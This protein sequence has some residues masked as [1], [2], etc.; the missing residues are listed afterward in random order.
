MSRTASS[1][2]H[3][4]PTLE[5]LEFRRF[6]NAASVV[7][8]TFELTLGNTLGTALRKQVSTI[9]FDLVG[10]DYWTPY[11]VIIDWGDGQT[12]TYTDT[13][14]N[15]VRHTYSSTGTYTVTASATTASGT[16]SAAPVQWNVIDVPNLAMD[17]VTDKPV[18]LRPGQKV[19]IVAS[20]ANTG[21]APANGQATLHFIASADESFDPEID[22]VF[23][24]RTINLNLR[25]GRAMTVRSTYRAP[26]DLSDDISQ[27]LFTVL[28]TDSR[29]VDFDSRE[30]ESISHASVN[31]ITPKPH[32][33]L[34]SISTVDVVHKGEQAPIY[35]KFKNT[36]KVNVTGSVHIQ[37]DGP[38]GQ[39]AY[40]TDPFTLKPRQTIN[41]VFPLYV[42][43]YVTATQGRYDIEIF[44]DDIAFGYGIYH[45]NDF[46]ILPAE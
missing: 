33:E 46:A 45:T 20:L 44:G 6:F 12:S 19:P 31:V 22:T 3:H 35:L 13:K 25:P 21:S 32:T 5:L 30:I 38:N 37:G 11:D 9:S 8:P 1:T 24:T 26:A 34:L 10:V 39:F 7:T 43:E 4:P 28:E 41:L 40:D 15:A 2:K 16:F 14:D 29:Q 27:Y 17:L 18:S 42:R 36:G 23:S